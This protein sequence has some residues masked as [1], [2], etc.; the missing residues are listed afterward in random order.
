MSLSSTVNIAQASLA[1][2]AALTTIVSRNIAGVNDPNYSRK[3]G[4]ITTSPGGAGVLTSVSR[5]TNDALFAN[6]LSANADAASSQA[7]SDGLNTLEQTVNLTNAASSTANA[8]N[9]GTSPATLLGAFTTAL[10]QYAASPGYTATGQ[11]V[12]TAAKALTGSL[13]SA[14]ATVQSVRAQADQNIASSVADVNSLLAQF[15]TVNDTIVKGTVSGTDVTDALDTRDKLLSALSQDI[16]ISTVSQPNGGTAIFT[17]SGATLFQ[18]T[19]RTV[20][21]APTTTYTAGT[22]GGSVSVDGVPVTGAS[23]VMGLKSGKIAG[24]TTL[25]DTTAVSYQ[26]QLDQ[27][28]SGLITSFAETD[29]TGGTAPTI[30]GLFTYAGAPAMPSGDPAGLAAG[31]SVSAS[32]DP[33]QGGTLSRLRDGGIGNPANPAYTANTSGAASYSTHLNALLSS[34]QTSRSFDPTSGGSATGTLADYAT[35]SVSWL[36]AARQ[37]ADN[38]TTDRSAVATQTAASLSSQNGV[39]LDDQLS[40]MLD[41]EHSYQ[42][43]AEL[44][45]TIKAMFTALFAA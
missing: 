15:K 16:G 18:G 4:N 7:L 10:Q 28:A 11:A 30:P 36:E 33:S 37:G 41:L 21:F 25:R 13:N 38:T 17:D 26:N 31:L 35:S 1:T 39:N 8:T 22:V 24:L 42:A 12:I 23:A 27:V 14:S 32:V 2:N 5:A 40:K 9:A 29:Q 6:L 44:I 45:S 43:S 20:S 19:A 34:L 3:T